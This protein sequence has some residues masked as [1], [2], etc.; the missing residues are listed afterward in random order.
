M[1]LDR[2]FWEWAE[3]PDNEKTPAKK[4]QTGT[5]CGMGMSGTCDRMVFVPGANI[6]KVVGRSKEDLLVSSQFAMKNHP[7]SQNMYQEVSIHLSMDHSQ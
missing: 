6:V 4:E 7:L 1:L 2:Y 5:R 3:P